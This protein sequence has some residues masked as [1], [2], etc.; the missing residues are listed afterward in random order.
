M[1]PE[2][3]RTDYF[4]A[5]AANYQLPIIDKVSLNPIRVFYINILKYEVQQTNKYHI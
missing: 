4:R 1:S 2:E 3:K 5:A